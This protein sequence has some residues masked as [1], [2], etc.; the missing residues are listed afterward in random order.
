[1]LMISFL[2]L[3]AIAV[4]KPSIVLGLSFFPEKDEGENL[5]SVSKVTLNPH[6]KYG[7]L[8]YVDISV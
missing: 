6:N 5:R 3:S 2:I 8:Q 7:P 1:M 4:L